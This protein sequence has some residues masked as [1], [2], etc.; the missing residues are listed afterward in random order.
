VA[1]EAHLKVATSSSVGTL[2]PHRAL[3]GS[4]FQLHGH[5]YEALTERRNF[6]PVPA[7]AER[8]STA[9]GR[10]WDIALAPGRR[11]SDGSP[12]TAADA[13]W[14][15]CRV[16]ALGISGAAPGLDRVDVAAADRLRIVLA[17]PQIDLDLDLSLILIA[18]APDRV[19]A[20]ATWA[21]C[22]PGDIPAAE[23]AELTG[24]IGSGPFRL[25]SAHP[26]DGYELERACITGCPAWERVSLIPT[27]MPAERMRLLA[28]GMVQVMEDVSATH[29]PY[30]A[31]RGDLVLTELPSDRVMFLA[32]N[33]GLTGHP[34]ADARVRRAIALA[35]DRNT[36][37]E[38]GSVGLAAP[39][40][41]LAR[42]DMTGIAPDRRHAT[43]DPAAA[44]SL[45]AAAGV[46]P[47]SPVEI[48]VS[49]ARGAD[50]GRIAGGIAAM[51][52]SVGLEARVTPIAGGE[53][54]PRLQEGRYEL[55][56]VLFG[57]TGTD[58]VQGLVQILRQDMLMHDRLPD[59]GRAELTRLIKQVDSAS[60]EPSSP[61]LATRML[62]LMEREVPLIPL[63]HIKDLI[64]HRQDLTITAEDTSR[65]FGLTATAAGGVAIR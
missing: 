40:G 47:G 46:P 27:P 21:G 39:V 41:Q 20:D 60:G 12:V 24:L 56:L 59:P 65:L 4:D 23:Q 53:M 9:D 63:L 37:V 7:L 6:R 33:A 34:L 2:D 17:A 22:G 54:T 15:L 44:R 18:K 45:L 36:L 25:L 50:S 16:R 26:G 62:D 29:L 28:E 30:L 61:D 57:L 48:V 8:W 1:G 19:R 49:Q 42:P 38:R 32:L 13:A 51:L 31:G 58:A 10:V 5:V 43:V 52:R 64:A 35:I 14:S 3:R 55:A 11:F